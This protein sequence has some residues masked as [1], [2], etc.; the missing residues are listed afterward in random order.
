MKR[1]LVRQGTSTLMVSL[2]SNWVKKHDLEKGSEVDLELAQDKV[3]VSAS[4]LKKKR[5]TK[6]ELVGLTESSLRTLIT[7]TYRKGFDRIEVLFKDN[8]QFKIIEQ[9]IKTK[10][11]GFEVINKKA[12]TCIIENITEGNK[13]LGEII[14]DLGDTLEENIQQLSDNFNTEHQQDE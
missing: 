6:I 8:K 3:L 14:S 13:D 10:L 1:K 2:P 5:S 12:N 7:N 4:E 9:T 11:I